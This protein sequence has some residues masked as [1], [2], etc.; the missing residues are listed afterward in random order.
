MRENIVFKG[1]N[2]ELQLLV[3]GAADFE[4]IYGQL[5]DKLSEAGDFFSGATIQ[6]P[7]GH[8]FDPEEKEKLVALLAAHG[9]TPAEPPAPKKRKTAVKQEPPTVPQEADENHEIQELVVP[10]TVRNGQ[11][12]VHKGSVVVIG[13][14]NPGAQVIA[15]GDIIVMGACRGVAHAGAFGNEAATITANKLLASQLRIAGLIA[16]SPDELDKPDY[17]ETARIKNGTV[18]IEPANIRG[19]E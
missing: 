8:K 15:G 18:V 6:L 4:G 11:Q 9:L 16:R 3:N 13:D 5:A 17:M 14:V 19:S 1:V 2:G 12:V 10:K 7:V